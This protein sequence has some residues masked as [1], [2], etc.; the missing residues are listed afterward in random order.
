MNT[1][2]HLPSHRRHALGIL[3]S[4]CGYL[5]AD[6]AQLLQWH[7]DT[8]RRWIDNFNASGTNGITDRQYEG[9]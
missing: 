1:K 5:P 8:V 2:R 6:M 9:G 7:L 4:S 3:L